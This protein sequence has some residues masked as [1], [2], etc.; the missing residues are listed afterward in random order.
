M[1][2]LIVG[3]DL[4]EFRRHYRTLELPAPRE[5]KLGE[6]EEMI[7]KQDP[8]HLI[9]WREG[10]AIL[11]HA[12]W[13]EAST[14]EHRDGDPRDREDREVLERLLGGKRDLVELHELW[15]KRAYRGRGYGKMFFEFFEDFIRSRGHDTIVYYTDHPAAIAICRKRGYKEDHLRTEGW[16]VFALR[17]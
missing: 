12:I 3:C 16:S 6:V 15:L 13:H 14:D 2:E 11:G 10:D 7:V 5:S 1:V 8:A 9:V 4:E 17:D